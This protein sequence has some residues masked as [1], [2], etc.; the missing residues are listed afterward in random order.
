MN[1]KEYFKYKNYR[2][3]MLTNGIERSA[4]RALLYSTGLEENDLKKPLIAIVNSFTEMVPG[5]EHLRSLA[6]DVAKGIW[7]A[8]GVPREFST[9]AICDGICQGHIG[10]RYP[11][12]SRDLIADTIE[13]MVE[14]HR[15]DAM[16][17]MPGCDKIVPGM[18]I[19][20]MRLNIPTIVVT[21]GPMMPG[22]G[23]GRDMLTLTDM[24]ELIG[25][26]QTGKITPE[27][28][29]EAEKTALPGVGTCSMLG[30]A[31]TMGCLTEVIGMSLPGCGLAHA[32]DAKKRRL[33]KES[34][35][36]IMEMLKKNLCPRDIVTREALLNGIMASMAMGASTNSTLHLP[37]IAHEAGIE[38]TLDDF[39][40]YSRKI[41][42][43]CNIKPSGDH[44]LFDLDINGGV[45]AVLKALESKLFLDVTTCTGKTLREELSKIKLVENDVIFPVSSPKKL[46]G[47]LAILHGN[48][49]PKGAVI[50]KSG[51]KP[52]MYYYKGKA[53]VF[54]SM[55]SACTAVSN[56]EIK[57][58][59]VIVITYEGPKG[60]PGMREMHMVTSLIVGRGMDEMCALVTDGRFSGSSRGPCIG[61]VSPEAA[62]GG[63]IAAVQDGDEIIIDI[64]NRSLTLLVSNEEIERRLANIVHVKKPATPALRRYAAAVTSADQGAVLHTP[65]E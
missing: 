61:H 62:A 10:M 34:G 15:F 28:L 58:G 30:T 51:C 32:V 33:A 57:E 38:L 2:S 65:K 35:R 3:G 29:L 4:H 55:E 59:T 31:N 52:S 22:R 1:Y 60:G 49:A 21:A 8:G 23:A 20:A 56:N 54:H 27:Q 46:D 63:P 19:A 16:V 44:S 48:L 24:R 64:E 6:Q 26:T 12:P 43:I 11:L 45:P 37:A 40:E 14:A 41:P 39:D 5:H 9:I 17:L 7:E 18:L 25:Q 47:G 53:R 36:H 13:Y 42:Y 50:K